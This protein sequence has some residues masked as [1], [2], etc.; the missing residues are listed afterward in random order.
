MGTLQVEALGMG[1]YGSTVASAVSQFVSLD[2]CG[3]MILWVTSE[4]AGP[5]SLTADSTTSPSQSYQGDFGLSPW[6]RVSLVQTRVLR[7]DEV[8]NLSSH[9]A[10]RSLSSSR[11]AVAGGT[12]GPRSPSGP[13]GAGGGGGGF[14]GGR[15]SNQHLQSS[16]V[17]ATIPGDV[18]SL[19][20][21]APRGK[22]CRVVRFGASSA[23][24]ALDRHYAG[25]KVE[26]RR[27]AGGGDSKSSES[28]ASPEETI[29]FYSNVTCIAVRD[30]MVPAGG[31]RSSASS[32]DSSVDD[33][34][35]NVRF[36]S[37][38]KKSGETM[39]TGG[40][41]KE[42]DDEGGVSAT[43]NKRASLQSASS[44][45][46]A[47]AVDV[48]S[49]LVLVG[50]RDGSVDLY[51][52]DVDAPLQ[53]WSLSNF[54]VGDKGSQSGGTHSQPQS[55]PVVMVKWCPRRPSAFLTADAAGSVYFFDL[56][57]N[58]FAPIFVESVPAKK[59]TP[60]TIDISRPRPGSNVVYALSAAQE[61]SGRGGMAVQVRRLNDVLLRPFGSFTG[62]ISDT[63]GAT[64]AH[65]EREEV[66]LRAA[67]SSWVARTST[68]QAVA[69][70]GGR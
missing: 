57:Q 50:R 25:D 7:I 26:V 16:A 55:P 43:S 38:E 21:A 34:S 18:S 69:V 44:S 19:L 15:P 2:V 13:G 8:T 4:G 3:V 17:M 47:G 64:G 60:N 14:G 54:D 22:V 41:A 39:S 33:D 32:G 30:S 40:A 11:H 58:P 10:M 42:G 35:E 5:D 1:D 70:M 23:L 67:M 37:E 27:S 48:G 59:L 31:R 63:K 9:G 20:A 28:A 24:G 49:P 29:Q 66:Q 36:S 56:L 62:G 61:A 52:I 68:S 65:M 45:S 51:Q 6:G 53:S 46:R 12:D